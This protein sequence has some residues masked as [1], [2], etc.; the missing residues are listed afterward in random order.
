M[1]ARL[2]KQDP[3]KE[4]TLLTLERLCLIEAI[5]WDMVYIIP[6][7]NQLSSREGAHSILI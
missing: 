5:F 2:F 4:G 3:E 6:G 7:A 1:Q